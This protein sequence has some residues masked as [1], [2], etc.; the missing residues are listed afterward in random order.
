[1]WAIE[2]G[3]EQRTIRVEVPASRLAEDPEL[4]MECRDA[5]TSQGRSVVEAQLSLDDPHIWF[6]VRSDT[7][8]LA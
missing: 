6:V 7:I 4:P 8:A 1:L 5:I 3:S 2:R